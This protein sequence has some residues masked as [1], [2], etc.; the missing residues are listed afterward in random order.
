MNGGWGETVSKRRDN[1]CNG[2]L[3]ICSVEPMLQGTVTLSVSGS[4]H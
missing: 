1:V 3:C 4:E 2:V